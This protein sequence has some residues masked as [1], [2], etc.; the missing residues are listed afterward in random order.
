MGSDLLNVTAGRAHPRGFETGNGMLSRNGL[1]ERDWSLHPQVVLQLWERF[2]RVQV[3][4]FVS[5][6]NTHCPSWFSMSDPPGPLGLDALPHDWPTVTRYAFP[7]FPLITN[8]LDRVSVKDHQLLL[9]APYWP[10]RPWFILLLSLSGILMAAA[11]KTQPA[12]SGSGDTLWHAASSFWAWPLR[13]V[14]G[15][16]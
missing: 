5:Q 15:Q 10:R 3:N 7:P 16:V 2:G 6:D 12:L 8:T 9:I 4:L 13:G 11:N 14:N 1:L